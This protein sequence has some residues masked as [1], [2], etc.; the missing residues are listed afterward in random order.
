MCRETHSRQLLQYP[1]G[2]GTVIMPGNDPTPT[3]LLQWMF[4]YFQHATREERLSLHIIK[5]LALV[6]GTSSSLVLHFYSFY[7]PARDDA[8]RI[9]ICPFRSIRW[10]SK[11]ITAQIRDNTTCYRRDVTPPSKFIWTAHQSLSPLK[12]V[13]LLLH[14]PFGIQI[15]FRTLVTNFK[16]GVVVDGVAPGQI[17]TRLWESFP[18][19]SSYQSLET[20]LVPF[21]PPAPRDTHSMPLRT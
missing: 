18:H 11:T 1:E 8:I 17:Q 10:I 3:Y 16:R 21:Q 6:L 14:H 5:V 13:V 2:S 4:K 19:N 7:S 15:N 20:T 9:L 12:V